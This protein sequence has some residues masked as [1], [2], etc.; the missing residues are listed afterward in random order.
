MAHPTTLQADFSAGVKKDFPR[1][2]MPKGSFFGGADWIPNLVGRLR[3]RGG[4]ANGSDSISAVKG[5]ASQVAAGIY[6]TYMAGACQVVIDEDGEIYK[7]AADTTVTDVGAGVA[8]FQDPVFHRDLV[9]IPAAG[10]ST[11][12]KKVSNSGGTLSAADLGGSPPDG[13]YAAVWGD[14]SL[15]ANTG[16][17]PQRLY[18]SDPGNPESWDTT[19]STWD[20]TQPINGLAVTRSYILAFHDGTMSRLRGTTPPPGSDFFNDDPLFNIGCTDARSIAVDG[21]R[22]MWCNGEGI[23]LTDGSADPANITKLCGMLTYWQETLA[24]YDKSSWTIAGGFERGK[25][26]VTVMNGATFKL[27][28]FIDLDALAWWPL[29]NLKANAFWPAQGSTDKLYFGRR[30]AARVGEVSS[31][32]MPS[33]AV[34]NDGDGTPVAATFESAYYEGAFGSKTLKSVYVD[35]QLTDYATDNPTAAIG[36]IK[37]PEATSYT[38]LST[39]IG[40]SA[41]KTTTKATVGGQVD[42]F[43]LEL[44]RANAGDFLLY[45]IEAEIAAR[46]PSRRAG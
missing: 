7:V 43:A 9:I 34:K 26:F 11:A 13:Q 22:I 3:E 42:G 4:W 17:E 28:A 6:A 44:V 21:D 36:Y 14:Y 31:I 12:P 35:N 32:F 25:Y 1:N 18:F 30:D 5:T 33:S 2:A 41:A 37:T 16:A 46:E 20:F 10:G 19:D 45:G 40:E 39:V 8:T 24:A 27:A 38:A 29:T 15:L 23:W